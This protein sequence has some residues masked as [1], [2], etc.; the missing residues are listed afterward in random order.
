VVLQWC[1]GQLNDTSKPLIQTGQY[2]YQ[3]PARGSPRSPRKSASLGDLILD[4]LIFIHHISCITS[5]LQSSENM[6][7]FELEERTDPADDGRSK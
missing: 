1:N 7:T 5:Q 6:H 3:R 4:S 2:F